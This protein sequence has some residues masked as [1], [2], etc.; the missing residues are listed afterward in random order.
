MGVQ[1][2]GEPL[3][4]AARVG[5]GH[6]APLRGVA[7]ATAGRPGSDRWARPRSS[8]PH[9][10]GAARRGG[11]AGTRPPA[12]AAR[13]DRGCGRASAP[14]PRG[15]RRAAPAAA[16]ARPA[17]RRAL[18]SGTEHA[19]PGPAAC[20]AGCRAA[21]AGASRTRR[22]APRR[23][24]GRPAR[25]RRRGPRRSPVDPDRAAPAAAPGAPAGRATGP[26]AAR[27]HGAVH[28]GSGRRS[29]GQV[30]PGRRGQ[31]PP[32]PMAAARGRRTQGSWS[33]QAGEPRLPD[34]VERDRVEQEAG[35]HGADGRSPRGGPAPVPRATGAIVNGPGH[36]DGRRADRA[37]AI[38][39]FSPIWPAAPLRC[40]SRP[41]GSGPSSPAPGTGVAPRACRRTASV[42]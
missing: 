22:A 36:A 33:G 29:R 34:D 41:A 39:G 12:A 16:R 13:P 28:D 21:R 10:P 11:P 20:A 3:P 30:L 14:M 23:G 15:P 19:G 1:Q 27:C 4:Q 9:R 24:S 6:G 7:A 26:A 5:R 42:R 37:P 2:L 18:R 35:V 32:L 40:G 38:G 31:R 8:A 17:R 25:R